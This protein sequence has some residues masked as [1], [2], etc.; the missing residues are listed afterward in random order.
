MPAQEELEPVKEFAEK[1]AKEAMQLAAPEIEKLL[2]LGAG[3]V[4]SNPRK[5]NASDLK[6][7]KLLELQQSLATLRID[8]QPKEKE[9]LLEEAMDDIPEKIWESLP[10][11][12]R[13]E[14][15]A[16]SILPL[17]DTETLG[18]LERMADPEAFIVKVIRSPQYKRVFAKRT[19]EFLKPEIER[20]DVEWSDASEV[21]QLV[22]TPSEI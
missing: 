8:L 10:A 12:V 6:L 17:L 2:E 1:K 5:G 3:D 11:G 4:E 19:L 22:D 14:H 13:K 7:S 18:D 15:V 16:E 9:Q 20:L 21:L